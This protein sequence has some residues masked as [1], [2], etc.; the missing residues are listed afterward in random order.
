MRKHRVV[1]R[2]YGIKYSW[3]GHKDRIRRSGQAPLV[4]VKNI[5]RSIPPTTWRWA[6]GDPW[7][8]DWQTDHCVNTITSQQYTPW[9][10][11]MI[12]ALWIAGV[13]VW[14]AE[15]TTFA[16]LAFIRAAVTIVVTLN[17]SLRMSRLLAIAICLTERT[18]FLFFFLSSGASDF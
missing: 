9:W 11:F 3:K 13:T 5:N 15:L 2:I 6:R 4:Y 8:N 1:G 16:T 18:M 17:E 10:V 14:I 12:F 7:R